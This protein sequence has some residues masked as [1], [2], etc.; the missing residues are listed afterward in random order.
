MMHHIAD[1]ADHIYLALGATDFRKQQNGLA[2][3][4][5][6]KFKLNPYS[7]TN[8]FLFCNKRRT[9]L[10]ALRWDKNGFILVSKFLSDDMKFQWPKNEGDV[11]NIAKRQLDWLLDGLN[12][13]QKK[14]L[15]ES[16][17]TTDIIF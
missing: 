16:I 6:L 8:L 5:S 17:N 1:G 15:R 12:I 9:S 14:A 11:R 10:R 4:V 7:G 13:D 3:L 2:T